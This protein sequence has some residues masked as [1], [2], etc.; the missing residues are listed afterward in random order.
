V[1]LLIGLHLVDIKGMTALHRQRPVE[2][3][4][5]LITAMTVIF[6]G[7]EQG[8]EIAIM[9]SIIAHLR[10][11]YRPF[12]L[13]LV[14][15]AGGGLRTISLV[16]QQQAVEGLLIYRFG[17]NLYF[18]NESS[19][20]EEIIALAKNTP[21]LKWFCISA[22]N[23]GDVDFT[24]AEALK[25]VYTQLKKWNITLVLSDVVMPVMNE[26]DIDGIIKMI[27]RDYIVESV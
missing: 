17:S 3:V 21:S 11:S 7:I 15:N 8:I 24:S 20:T 9:L 23:I 12:N 13:L 4:V 2:F 26:L 14:L 6:I 5:A 10:H 25:K 16:E 1:V 22:S 19:F 18:A 27:G